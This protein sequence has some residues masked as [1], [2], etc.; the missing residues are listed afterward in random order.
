MRSKKDSREGAFTCEYAAYRGRNLKRL[1]APSYQLLRYVMAL[2]SGLLLSSAFPPLEWDWAAWVA[3]V[4]MMLMPRPVYGARTWALGWVFGFAF[5]ATSLAWLNEVGFGAGI[6]V[7]LICALFPMLWYAFSVWAAEWLYSKGMNRIVPHSILPSARKRPAQSA[8]G[9][10]RLL[11]MEVLAVLFIPAAWVALEWVR[12][13]FLTGFPWNLVGVS[14]WQ[15]LWLLPLTRYTGVYGISFVVLA[16][17]VA[18]AMAIKN[19]FIPAEQVPGARRCLP[20]LGAALMTALP[21]GIYMSGAD[22][23]GA[24]HSFLRAGVVQGKIPQDPVYRDNRFNLALRVYRMYTREVVRKG[25]SLDVVLWPE[26]PVPAALRYSQEYYGAVQRLIREIQTPMLIGSTD[27]QAVEESSASANSGQGGGRSKEQN[28]RAYNSVFQLDKKGRILEHYRKTHL[29]PFGEYIPLERLWPWVKEVIPLGHSLT[30]GQEYTLF[31]LTPERRCGVNICYEDVFPGISRRFVKRGANMLVTI[32][33]DAW[34]GRSAGPRQHM[35][36]A[37]FRAVENGR[38]LLRVGNNSYSCLVYPDGRVTG[39]LRDPAT[40]SP[41][42]RGQGTY[43]VPL[44]EQNGTTWYT[45]HGDVFAVVCF[46]LTAVGAVF[47]GLDVFYRKE[48]AL[49]PFRG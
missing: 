35:I 29:V 39:V 18:L 42:Y 22:H 20:L 21:A 40:G 31:R 27:Y 48:R 9:H 11:R 46:V 33:N 14:Q 30:S 49:K 32:T 10:G 12:S 41:F 13:W 2:C 16:V 28:V 26:T 47:L 37:V 8:V 38:P 7:A 6:V 44:P 36:H 25:P 3:L 5:F 34:Y 4:P 43:F 45:R 24:Q 1:V 17:N 23:S 19:I 15:Q